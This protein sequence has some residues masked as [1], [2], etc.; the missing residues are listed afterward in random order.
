M[1]KIPLAGQ[2]HNPFPSAH[3]LDLGFQETG[4]EYILQPER[5]GLPSSLTD[6]IASKG[7]DLQEVFLLFF[8]NPYDQNNASLKGG[9]GDFSRPLEREA[10]A[11]PTQSTYQNKFSLKFVR[12]VIIR[13]ISSYLIKSFFYDRLSTKRIVD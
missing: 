9:R 2:S 4:L 6:R 3:G 7:W 11:S 10:K 8:L 13:V 12:F 5:K 1:R